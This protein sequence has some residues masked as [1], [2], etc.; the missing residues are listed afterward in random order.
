[1]KIKFLTQV[2]HGADLYSH[3]DTADID[4]EEADALIQIGAAEAVIDAKDADAAEVPADV[5]GAKE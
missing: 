3:G 1:M 2:W 5:D 4:D